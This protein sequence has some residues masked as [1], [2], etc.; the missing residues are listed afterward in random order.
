MKKIGVIALLSI[1]VIA[2]LA[3][4]DDGKQKLLARFH[5]YSITQCDNFILDNSHFKGGWTFFINKHEGGIDGISTEVSVIQILGSKND[6]VKIDSS[7]IQT[8][9]AC[10]L[11]QRS[12]ITFPNLCADIID[13]QYWRII[14]ELPDQDYSV[15]K[16]NNGIEVYAKDI[17]VGDANVCI[18]EINIRKKGRQG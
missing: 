5:D 17:V 11:H 15:Y 13:S 9:K 2:A 14:A 10:F 7:Y 16:N 1:T 8:K 3:H 6:T 18:Q 12:T 4:G